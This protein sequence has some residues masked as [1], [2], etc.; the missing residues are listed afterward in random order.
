[1]SKDS[2]KYKRGL[3]VFKDLEAGFRVLLKENIIVFVLELVYLDG[4]LLD[5]TITSTIIHSVILILITCSDRH[6]PFTLNS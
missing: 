4:Q 6:F 5:H 2:K 1:M 3:P